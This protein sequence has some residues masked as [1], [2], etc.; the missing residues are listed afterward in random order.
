MNEL[1]SVGS[2]NTWL[3]RNG[4]SLLIG[5]A[6]LISSYTINGYRITDLENQLQ[7]AN[8]SI[9]TLNTQS[10]QTQVALAQIQ[11][12]LTYIKSSVDTLTV[13]NSKK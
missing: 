2:L 10:V 8:T 4:W 3:Q 1:T 13:D 12:D 9:T 11:V 6:A 5:V 7:S